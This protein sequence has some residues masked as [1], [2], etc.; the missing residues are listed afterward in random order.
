LTATRGLV[1]EEEMITPKGKTK[2]EL[3][4]LY[5]CEM[6]QSHAALRSTDISWII[7]TDLLNTPNIESWD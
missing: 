5:N 1:N 7:E 3:N 2:S 4:Q 6:G